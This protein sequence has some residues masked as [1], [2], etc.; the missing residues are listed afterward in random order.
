MQR[1][2]RIQSHRV[3]DLLHVLLAVITMVT[4]QQTVFNMWVLL[5]FDGSPIRYYDFPA[6]GTVE[7]KEKTYTYNELLEIVGEC[8]L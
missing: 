4:A 1:V 8:L 3:V 7:V 6:E 2:V 5:D